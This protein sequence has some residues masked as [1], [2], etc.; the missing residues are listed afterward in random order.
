[1]SI[2]DDSREPESERA[3][4]KRLSDWVMSRP[5]VSP[6]YE[7]APLGCEASFSFGGDLQID[8]VIGELT[9][10]IS[11]ISLSYRRKA[12]NPLGGGLLN[13][14]HTMP[15]VN[16]KYT[17]KRQHCKHHDAKLRDIYHIFTFSYPIQ[18]RA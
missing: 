17:Q 16:V 11:R 18:L 5:S 2:E 15:I 4:R 9:Q 7:K 12:K 14:E 3:L 6:E 1:M 13:S 10:F 8:D